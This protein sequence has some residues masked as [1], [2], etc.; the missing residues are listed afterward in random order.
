MAKA[1]DTSSTSDWIWLSDALR[2]ATKVLGSQALAKRRLKELLA[3][4]QTA[5]DLHAVREGHD[6]PWGA[7]P[8]LGSRMACH[9]L[10]LDRP[11]SLDRLGGQ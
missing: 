10:F 3:I 8:Q 11:V 9:D 5:V 1:N 6:E 4:R 7:E 2:E